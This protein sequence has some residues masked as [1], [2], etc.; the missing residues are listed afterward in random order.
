MITA[1]NTV[2][3]A[4]DVWTVARWD[5]RAHV[6]TNALSDRWRRV[7]WVSAAACSDQAATVELCAVCPVASE[8][9]AA[10]LI[11][12]DPAPLRAGHT[13]RDRLVLWQEL[14][15]AAWADDPELYALLSPTGQ[16]RPDR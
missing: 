8:C 9:L 13:V 10:A 6:V 16:M 2:N 11:I 15:D 3:A 5:Y 7:G 1:D 12:E 14:E 4:V